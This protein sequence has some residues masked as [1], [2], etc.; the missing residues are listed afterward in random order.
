M[1]KKLITVITIIAV[2]GFGTFA[3]AHW[4]GGYGMQGEYG[5]HQGYYGD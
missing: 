2:V 5:I 4:N 3:F 1:S